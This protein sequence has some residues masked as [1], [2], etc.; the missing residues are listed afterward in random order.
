MS[1]RGRSI[2]R[3]EEGDARQGR[4]VGELR[5]LDAREKTRRHAM[6]RENHDAETKTR[7]SAGSMQVETG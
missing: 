6:E 2:A 3:R 7:R 1:I 5:E 4:W